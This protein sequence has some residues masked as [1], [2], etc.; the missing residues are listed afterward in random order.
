MLPRT[1]MAVISERV[2]QGSGRGAGRGA[3]QSAGRRAGRGVE[4]GAVRIMSEEQRSLCLGRDICDVPRATT[5][6]LQT[7]HVSSDCVSGIFDGAP[8]GTLQH[9]C[10]FI[11]SPY[12]QV[13]VTHIENNR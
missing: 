7:G 4:P 11:C 9:A 13:L 5:A 6:A 1:V 2:D 12:K 10:S 3:G 8:L